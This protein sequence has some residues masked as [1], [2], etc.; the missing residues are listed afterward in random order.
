[1]SVSIEALQ[2]AQFD[3]VWQ[4][5][6]TV[7]REK[8][9]LASQCAP[10]PAQM[11]EYLQTYIDKGQPYYVALANGQVCGWCG[12]QPLHGQARAHVG[13]LGMGLLPAMRGQ[14]IG[15]RL[16]Q[17]ALQAAQSYG[18]TRV[19]LAVRADN[20]RAIALYERLGF[21]R[22]GVLRNGFCVDGVY[23]DVYTM[24]LLYKPVT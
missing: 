11:R 23:F 14:G 22:E 5:F 19:E 8:H 9:Y 1:M 20:V 17:A 3:A 13:M 2:S 15:E 4:V 21:V 12:V 24:A 18:F 10:E 7:A 16:M 6:D